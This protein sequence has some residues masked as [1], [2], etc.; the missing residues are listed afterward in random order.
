MSGGLWMWVSGWRSYPHNWFWE[1]T[2]K[3]SEVECTNDSVTFTARWGL[4][5]AH[6]F[7]AHGQPAWGTHST[8]RINKVTSVRWKARTDS[9]RCPLTF[10]YMVAG[11]RTCSHTDIS[12]Q[13]VKPLF[14]SSCDIFEARQWVLAVLGIFRLLS[15][16]S[17]VGG[18]RETSPLCLEFACLFLLKRHR[19]SFHVFLSYSYIFLGDMSITIFDT[20]LKCLLIAEP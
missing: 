10:T 18:Y 5:Q 14:Q 2:Y 17:H 16:G 1:F 8:S 15:L 12:R 20:F 9:W 11:A 19:A 3:P 13:T 4:R 7:E 6:H